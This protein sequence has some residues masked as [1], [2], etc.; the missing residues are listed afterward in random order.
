[1]RTSQTRDDVWIG[2]NISFISGEGGGNLSGDVFAGWVL[3]HFSLKEECS[4]RSARSQSDRRG[5]A[6]EVEGGTLKPLKSVSYF[7]NGGRMFYPI[8]W[9]Q[10]SGGYAT[11]KYFLPANLLRRTNVDF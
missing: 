7:L 9:G 5:G 8:R 2:S 11:H 3:P 4:G 1:M 10:C 6:L